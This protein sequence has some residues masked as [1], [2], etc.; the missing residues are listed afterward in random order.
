MSIRY[1]HFNIFYMSLVD[2]AISAGKTSE[3]LEV[4]YTNHLYKIDWVRDEKFIPKDC[5][6]EFQDLKKIISDDVFKQIDKE[7]A[8]YKEMYE[9]LGG[10][11]S[12]EALGNMS[13][14]RKVIRQLHWRKSKK[15]AELIAA[16]HSGLGFHIEANNIK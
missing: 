16:L 11:V 13:N 15:A 2:L 3:R 7:R 12:E 5:L 8:E 10:K 4:A 14:G 6:K 9:R 1:L